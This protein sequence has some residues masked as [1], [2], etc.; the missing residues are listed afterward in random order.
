MKNSTLER[1][2]SRRKNFLD[3]LVSFLKFESISAGGRDKDCITCAEWLTE[4]LKRIGF[5]DIRLLE[6]GDQP[7]VYASKVV[8]PDAPTILIYGHYDVQPA[9][10]LDEWKTPPFDPRII[11]G[12]I[13]AR[14]A[15]DNKGQI[16]T[17]LRALDAVIATGGLAVNVKILFEGQEEIGSAGVARVIADNRELLQADA[18]VAS[19]MP[20]YADCVPSMTHMLRGLCTYEVTFHGPAMDVHSGHYGG[21]VVNPIN[22]LAGLIASMHDAHGRVTIPGFYDDVKPV[23][24]SQ[25]DDWRKLPFDEAA[26]AK[27]IGLDS[28]VGGEAG[29]EP[30]VREWARPTLECNGIIGGY[31]GKGVKTIIPARAS[32]KISIRL[33]ADQCPKNMDSLVRDYVLSHIPA[34]IRCEFKALASAPAVSFPTGSPLVARAAAA[35]EKVFGRKPVFVGAGGSIPIMAVISDKISPNIFFINMG[36]PD[37]GIHSPNERFRLDFFDRGADAICRFLGS[38]MFK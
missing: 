13:Y 33:V 37:D 4:L 10:P 5:D 27:F 19:D 7:C 8:S 28:F 11:D 32:V 31:T 18:V 20:W 22:A 12:F 6:C 1:L 30:V 3:A 35:T 24:Q 38:D 2:V 15:S 21:L 36:L 17:W 25:L 9:D 34:G 29:L 26:S 14:G 16:M 23:P